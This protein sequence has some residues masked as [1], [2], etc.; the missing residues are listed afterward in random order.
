M[1]WDL[2]LRV[3]IQKFD[4]PNSELEEMWTCCRFQVHELDHVCMLV[5]DECMYVEHLKFDYLRIEAKLNLN[6]RLWIEFKHYC[7]WWIVTCL[8]CLVNSYMLMMA[9]I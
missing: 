8:W 7:N 6:P 3:G 1:I 4:M 5:M 9:S 2:V